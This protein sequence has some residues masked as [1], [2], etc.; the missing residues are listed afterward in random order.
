MYRR[1]INKEPE[2]LI[3]KLTGSR[4]LILQVLETLE[5]RFIIIETS[6]FKPNQRGDGYHVF[7]TITGRKG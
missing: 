4:T 2:D 6:R 7:V 5:E 1:P 3:I